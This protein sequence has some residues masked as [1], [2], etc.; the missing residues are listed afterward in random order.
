MATGVYLYDHIRSM[1][2]TTIPAFIIA[3]IIYTVYGLTHI[4][5]TMSASNNVTLMLSQMDMIY[6]WNILLLLPFVIMMI[7]CLFIITYFPPIA[8]WLPTLFNLC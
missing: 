8:T 6:N 7:I 1:L 3:A 2:W 5:H 4:S